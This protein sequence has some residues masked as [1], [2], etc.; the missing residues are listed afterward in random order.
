MLASSF[1]LAFWTFVGI[2]FVCSLTEEVRYPRRAMPRRASSIGLI[3][4]LGTSWLMGLGVAG[5]TPE[6][7][8]TWADVAFG[9]AGCDG[10]CPQLAVGEEFF[11][12]FGR[13]LM[14]L[15]SVTA[16]LG[17]M[18]VA[19]AAIPRII[20]GIA[21]DGNFFGPHLSRVFG[22]VHPRWRTPVPAII[23]FGVMSTG[24]AL[25]SSDVVDW[26]FSGAYVWILIYIAFNVLCFANRVL[27]PGEDHL[28]PKWFTVVPLIG[29]V[30]T[31]VAL[32]Y[33]YIGV[34]GDYY[35][36]ALIIIG[37]AAVATLIAHFVPKIDAPAEAERRAGL[38]TD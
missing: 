27:H 12:G 8:G 38:V 21:R 5:T 14:A 4:I 30:L 1:V 6:S 13:G 31:G 36:R 23:L 10:S 16:T 37:V 35:W 19:F 29:A 34:H 17:S 9:P 24:F 18:I 20:F 11:G 32:Y 3:V 2:E 25:F 26:I 7:G 15:A 28:F 33:A 22:F